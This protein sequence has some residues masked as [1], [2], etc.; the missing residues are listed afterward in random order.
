MN[1]IPVRHSLRRV[2][3]FRFPGHGQPKQKIL[4]IHLIRDLVLSSFFQIPDLPKYNWNL[5]LGKRKKQ[6]KNRSELLLVV[7][8]L[9][10]PDA[11]PTSTFT[12]SWGKKDIR[13]YYAAS[14][15]YLFKKLVACFAHPR[16]KTARFQNVSFLFVVEQ[17]LSCES[18]EGFMVLHFS[19]IWR[20]TC[21][22]VH[23]HALIPRHPRAPRT[24]NHSFTHVP[25]Q[26]SRR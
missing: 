13:I 15:N 5:S 19:L 4:V 16:F 17:D 12:E 9:A 14:D 25:S 20:A 22:G 21:G 23:A 11:F 6:G 7:E 18:E 24:P 8:T 3:E 10:V 2:D 26:D 1:G